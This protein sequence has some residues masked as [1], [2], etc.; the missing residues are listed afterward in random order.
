MTAGSGSARIHYSLFRNASNS[1]QPSQIIDNKVNHSL[2]TFNQVFFIIN[3]NK[4]QG[5]LVA[6]AQVRNFK[7][8]YSGESKDPC[9]SHYDRIM[10]QFDAAHQDATNSI[11]IYQQVVNLGERTPQAYL[12]SVNTKNGPR[13]FCAH[14]PSKYASA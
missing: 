5:A 3:I 1:E 12:F 11:T 6:Q 9:N 7:K 13:I 8:I 4:D 2:I 10:D 14:F